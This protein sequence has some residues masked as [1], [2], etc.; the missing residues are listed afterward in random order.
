MVSRL[1]VKESDVKIGFVGLGVMGFGMAANILKAGY[2]LS[3][4]DVNEE[5]KQMLAQKGAKA[6]SSAKEVARN[7]D[8]ILTSL[9]NSNIVEAV[10]LGK[11]GILEG[12][13]SGD[14]IIDMSSITPSTIKKIGVR[15]AE[16]NVMLLDSPV[17]GGAKGA[18]EGTLTIMVGGTE[19]AFNKAKPVLAAIGSNISYIGQLGAGDTIKAVNNLLLGL[20]MIAVAEAF[21]LGKKAGLDEKVMYDIIS[22]SSGSSYALTA[23]YE[24]YFSVGNFEPGFMIDLMHKDMQLAVE[25][26]KDLKVPLVNGT[27]AQQFFQMARVD[28]LGQKDISAV[29]KV[30]EK[31]A[32]VTV[33]PRK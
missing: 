10:V 9:P 12:A 4:F 23:K 2:D 27:M 17:S 6:M 25:M 22:K 1:I 13:K 16:K 19:E 18:A 30:F 21:V 33:G 15:C 26:A 28:G 11:D 8:V 29:F 31:W 14:L 24:K 5:K 32:D 7:S 3:V 20:N